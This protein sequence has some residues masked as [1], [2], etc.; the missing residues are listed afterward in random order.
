M[1]VNHIVKDPEF[2]Q[3]LTDLKSRIR[4]SQIKA[5]IK[6][7]DEMLRLYWDLGHDIVVR[8]M[9]SVWGSGFFKQLSKELKG[10]F[11]DMQGFS[12]RN[13][14]YIKQF[15]L[16]Y[17][18]DDKIV[19]QL[20]AQLK[21]EKTHQPGAEIQQLE[22][23]G[24]TGRHQ[25]TDELQIVE[26]KSNMFIQQV[27][28]QSTI[29]PIF[30]IPWGHHMLLFHQLKKAVDNPTIGLL[31]CKTKDNVDV[32]YALESSSQPIG[33]SEYTLSKLVPENFKSSLPSIEEIE[34]ELNISV[35]QRK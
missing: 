29:H 9:D 2:K 33:V 25:V 32:Q 12:K 28:E 4:Q 24:N 23:S 21:N 8:Q 5:M 20:V 14:F 34:R 1:N 18:Q 17:C 3:W 10:E 19:Q 7:N 31:I 6:V 22:N 16:F 27:V 30:Q 13:L 26:N 15:Y 35:R 11:P